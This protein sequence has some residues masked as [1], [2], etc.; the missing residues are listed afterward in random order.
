MTHDAE[1]G[2]TVKAVAARTGVPSATLRAWERRYGVVTPRRSAGGYRLY[3][4]ADVARIQRVRAL[5]AQGLAPREATAVVRA[6]AN[7]PGGDDR[8]IDG[9]LG[10][11][12]Q[13]DALAAAFVALDEP[14]ARRVLDEA[15]ANTSIDRIVDELLSPLL[16]RVGE[17][18]ARGRLGVEIE[19][20][21]STFLRGV[22]GDLLADGGG[23]ARGPLLGPVVL[24]CP[25]GERHELGLMLLAVALSRAG[26]GVINLGADLPFDALGSAVD[27]VGAVAVCLTLGPH[28][29][30]PARRELDELVA[31]MATH[32]RLLVLWGG[33]VPT[34]WPERMADFPGQ[35]IAGPAGAA[36]PVIIGQL[37]A[38]A[39]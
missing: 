1:P 9:P 20:F 32:P 21:A 18:W 38:V 15:L 11:A 19:H 22:I 35:R 12:A 16:T 27:R 34:W 36:V 39:A 33:P 31:V 30:T 13:A 6:A 26:V 4:E 17:Q 7:R 37:R 25:P 14:A 24:A 10:L 29:V 2:Y 28:A 8:T 3:S 23:A 5:V